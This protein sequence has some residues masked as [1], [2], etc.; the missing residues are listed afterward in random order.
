MAAGVKH[1]NAE[2]LELEIGALGEGG[3]DDLPGFFE[4]QRGHGN[5][6]LVRDIIG[7][8]PAEAIPVSVEIASCEAAG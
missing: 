5:L 8:Q 3:I 1:G 4:R 6:L 7:G 2:R